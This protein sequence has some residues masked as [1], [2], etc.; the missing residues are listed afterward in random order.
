M[1]RNTVGTYL[2]HANST[3]K[4]QATSQGG[5][6]NYQTPKAID[7]SKVSEKH[8]TSV[9]FKNELLYRIFILAALLKFNL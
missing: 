8:K 3:K 6:I 2:H 7:V 4:N 9:F 1:L 5:K